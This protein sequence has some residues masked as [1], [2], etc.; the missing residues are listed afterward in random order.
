MICHRTVIYE[1]DI[2]C[3]DSPGHPGEHEADLSVRS[4][5]QI[6]RIRAISSVCVPR[7]PGV[8]ICI[9][10]YSISFGIKIHYLRTKRTHCKQRDPICPVRLIDCTVHISDLTDSSVLIHCRNL[11]KTLAVLVLN[12]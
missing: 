4:H 2:R 5:A 12:V 8:L 6:C 7:A 3:I 9:I 1:L 10:S 11:F